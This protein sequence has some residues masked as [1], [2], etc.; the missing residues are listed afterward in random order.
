M[1]FQASCPEKVNNLY[2]GRRLFLFRNALNHELSVVGLLIVL[3]HINCDFFYWPKTTPSYKAL[4]S[5]SSKYAKNGIGES[6]F[7]C[8][9]HCYKNRFFLFF[10]T[11]LSVWYFREFS[12]L[13]QISDDKNKITLSKIQLNHRFFYV[14]LT[15]DFVFEQLSCA[16]HSDKK[17]PTNR[18]KSINWTES[19][20]FHVPQRMLIEVEKNSIDE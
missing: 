15:Y 16:P 6:E 19:N 14:E 8:Y 20:E 10:R 5:R 1:I 18:A 3:I 11:P 7:K 17:N 9:C 4:S 12:I 13:L 2:D